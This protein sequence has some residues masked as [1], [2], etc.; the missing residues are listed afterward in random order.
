MDTNEGNWCYGSMSTSSH[1]DAQGYLRAEEYYKIVLV[2]EVSKIVLQG[3]VLSDNPEL[4]NLEK[5]AL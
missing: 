2:V 5:K 4:G 1:I 3:E